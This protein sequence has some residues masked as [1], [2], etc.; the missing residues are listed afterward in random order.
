MEES[1]EPATAVADIS[2][3]TNDSR[4]SSCRTLS[5][6]LSPLPCLIGGVD[7]GDGSASSGS[8]FNSDDGSNGAVGAG[9]SGDGDSEG[10][11][12]EVSYK[13]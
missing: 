11:V 4:R 6:S 2:D 13:N 3:S 1:G 9:G 5:R 10:S 8:N 7:G 12:E